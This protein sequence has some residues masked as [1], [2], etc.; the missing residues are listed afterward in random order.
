[1]EHFTPILNSPT[2]MQLCWMVK[3][4]PP[5]PFFISIVCL[6]VHFFWG[7]GNNLVDTDFAKQGRIQD[8]FRGGAKDYMYMRERT[9]RT[10]AKSEVPFGRDPGPA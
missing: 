10:S 5:P 3:M 6:F 2:N 4:L 9:L 1:M 7:G 8:S